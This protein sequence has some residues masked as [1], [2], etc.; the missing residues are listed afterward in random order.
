MARFDR[1]MTG[2]RIEILL[3]YW[4]GNRRICKASELGF[5]YSR[6]MRRFGAPFPG[7]SHTWLAGRMLGTA[8]VQEGRDAT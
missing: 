7:N 6:L 3:H 1:G 5:S 8:H 4:P 2:N